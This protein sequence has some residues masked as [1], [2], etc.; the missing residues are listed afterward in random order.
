M[1]A[2]PIHGMK[3]VSPNDGRCYECHAHNLGSRVGKTRL[4][5][6]DRPLR[7][8]YDAGY[9][10]TRRPDG[11]F[12]AGQA[13]A[14]LQRVAKD[15][16]LQS[17]VNSM[18]ARPPGVS[19]ARFGVAIRAASREPMLA[20][21]PESIASG[22]D[23]KH[24]DETVKKRSIAKGGIFKRIVVKPTSLRTA[25]YGRNSA[26]W[27]EREWVVF[28]LKYGRGLVVRTDIGDDSKVFPTWG[29]LSSAIRKSGW[30]VIR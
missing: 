5:R 15:E 12:D 16:V 26:F 14:L 28:T 29:E 20:A 2:C 21:N 11:T 27:G 22:L 6:A 24:A 30:Q 19:K 8:D 7:Y 13:A 17:E 1:K 3:P 23:W 25:K 4:K 9:T 18:L 10:I